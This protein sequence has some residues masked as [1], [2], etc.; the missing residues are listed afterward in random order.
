MKL[1][2]NIVAV[3]LLIILSISTYHLAIVR[4]AL[5]ADRQVAMLDVDQL[6]KDMVVALAQSGAAEDEIRNKSATF[7]RKVE[8]AARLIESR[9]RVVLINAAAVVGSASPDYT[10]VVREALELPPPKVDTP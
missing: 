10:A 6:L 2:V 9:D 4:P 3:S 7:R 5:M 8:E 1:V